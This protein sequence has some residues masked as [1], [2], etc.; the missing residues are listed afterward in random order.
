M[1]EKWEKVSDELIFKRFRKIINRIFIN[2]QGS[3]VEF[4]I[5]QEGDPACVLAITTNNEVILA[6][7]F[8]PGPELVMLELPGGGIEK[9]ESPNH[10]IMRE[11]LEETGYKVG[12]LFLVKF[13]F[14]DA[15][16]TGR[17]Y[18]F[19]AT[20]CEKIAEPVTTPEEQTEVVLM[21]IQEFRDHL[22]TGQLSDTTTGYLGLDHLNLL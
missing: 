16:S 13:G 15:Y 18:H 21:S 7:Q 10:A 2:H 12:K 14:F 9:G 6:K 8:R 17:R 3:R 22:R 5:K 19:V 1:I 20:G 11:L 4:D